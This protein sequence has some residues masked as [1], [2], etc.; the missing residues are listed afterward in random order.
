[1]NTGRSIV[2]AVAIVIGALFAG[3]AT[4]SAADQRIDMEIESAWVFQQTGMPPSYIGFPATI[5]RSNP[6][7]L[8]GD[9]NPDGTFT[10]PAEQFKLDLV[11]PYPGVSFT[12]GAKENLT[13]SY[14][15]ARG[16]MRISIP[17]YYR[18][19]MVN[20]DP[21]PEPGD[22]TSQTC[23]ISGFTMDGDTSG[24]LE[25]S[26]GAKFAGSTFRNG[27]GEV[28]AD[29]NSPIGSL[30]FKGV[31]GTPDSVC[32]DMSGGEGGSFAGSLYFEASAEVIDIVPPIETQV[33]LKPAKKTLKA[34]RSTSLRL[35]VE[36]STD[37]RRDIKVSFRS[38]NRK[39]TVRKS[40]V[41]NVPARSALL[42][43]VKVKA[44]KKAKGKARITASATGAASSVS[45]IT[46]KAA[47]KPKK[48]R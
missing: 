48:R 14:D 46:V 43:T 2:A 45:T 35:Q 42:T 19:T 29:W 7:S 38:S 44:A 37:V 34:G 9:F 13:G 30:S 6:V 31:N 18:M 21:D 40:V 22:P 10:I 27:V 39:V 23:E 12:F 17:A 28:L 20:S 32:A 26:S 16:E 3:G 25:T 33:F 47:K 41:V 36:N 4:A 8:S 11:P 24:E 1:M 5:T 15:E